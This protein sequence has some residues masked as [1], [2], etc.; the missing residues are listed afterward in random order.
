MFSE[1]D[2][3]VACMPMTQATHGCFL[4][5]FFLCAMSNVSGDH[6]VYLLYVVFALFFLFF[7]CPYWMLVRSLALK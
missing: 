6:K 4:T 3:M 1:I 7:L 2:E 5:L